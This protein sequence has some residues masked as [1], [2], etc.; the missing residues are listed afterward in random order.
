MRVINKKALISTAAQRF[1]EAYQRREDW[2]PTEQ[3]GDASLIYQKL[4]GLPIGADEDAIMAI[5]GDSRWTANICDECGEDRE[6]T[7]LLGEE[8]HHST[9]MAAICLDCLKQARRIGKASK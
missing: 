6:I 1:R 7:I 5:T 8:I 9:D 3:G 2:L 4:A